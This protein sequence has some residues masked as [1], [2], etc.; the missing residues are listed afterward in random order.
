MKEGRSLD[1]SSLRY[2]LILSRAQ[3]DLLLMFRVLVKCH[4]GRA[5]DHV[6]SLSD[7]NRLRS[8][9]G[10]IYLSPAPR[11]TDFGVSATGRTVRASDEPPDE[12]Q[13]RVPTGPSLPPGRA[14]PRTPRSG[15]GS[16]LTPHCP[17]LS[18]SRSRTYFYSPS[19]PEV[20][21]STLQP[22]VGHNEVLGGSGRDE[23]TTQAGKD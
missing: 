22:V 3:M 4:S 23:G 12:H 14:C 2:F 21:T 6:P 19:G 10:H 13:T 17:P 8:G 7:R 20:R 16:P 15:S 5:T 1:N 18:G 9:R 11:G